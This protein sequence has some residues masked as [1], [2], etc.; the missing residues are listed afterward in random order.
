MA[1]VL[2]NSNQLGSS[3]AEFTNPSS[4]PACW[5]KLRVKVIS[6]G[7]GHLRQD[8]S[9]CDLHKKMPFQTSHFYSIAQRIIIEATMN[10]ATS[11]NALDVGY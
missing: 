4:E 6:D 7:V 2:Q 3:A 11:S 10:M 5:R 9:A 1:F 8:T